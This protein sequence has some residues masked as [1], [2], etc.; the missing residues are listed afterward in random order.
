MLCKVWESPGLHPWTQSL[1]YPVVPG[2]EPGLSTSQP[3]TSWDWHFC[4]ES[5]LDLYDANTE[6]MFGEFSLS[7]EE[8][9]YY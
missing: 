3:L 9:R 4:T 2:T 8:P 7:S 5:F 1:G 6:Y